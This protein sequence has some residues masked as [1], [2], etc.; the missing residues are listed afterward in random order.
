MTTPTELARQHRLA[1]LRERP[2]VRTDV[3][4]PSSADARAMQTLSEERNV[5]KTISARELV[6]LR[7]IASYNWLHIGY[8]PVQILTALRGSGLVRSYVS[9]TVGLVNAVQCTAGGLETLRSHP[10]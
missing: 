4:V 9:R 2:I 3:D 10:V 5:K 1:A 7:R 6:Y 8:V